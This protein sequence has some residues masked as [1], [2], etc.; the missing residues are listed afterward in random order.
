MNVVH[1]LVLDIFSTKETS[2]LKFEWF[3][4]DFL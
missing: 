3:G 4:Y 1:E 2:L